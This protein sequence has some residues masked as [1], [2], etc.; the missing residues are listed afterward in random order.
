MIVMKYVRLEEPVK[1]LRNS[2]APVSTS[3]NVIHNWW[4]PLNVNLAWLEDP[5]P[6]IEVTQFS[7][8]LN[9]V[10]PSEISDATLVQMD[11]TDG[12]N[13]MSVFT[14]SQVQKYSGLWVKIEPLRYW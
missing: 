13:V 8:S 12:K 7:T 3:G 5:M 1:K 14:S 2:R 10:L 11:Q 6:H 9:S 4:T